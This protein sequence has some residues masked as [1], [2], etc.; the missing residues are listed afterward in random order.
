MIGLPKT[1][2][3]EC[4][5]V[6]IVETGPRNGRTPVCWSVYTIEDVQV[7]PPIC[8]TD[9]QHIKDF[10]DTIVAVYSKKTFACHRGYFDYSITFPPT[11]TYG[12]LPFF[13][14]FNIVLLTMATVSTTMCITIAITK[15]S[16]I[17][18]LATAV[19]WAL[20]RCTTYETCS[21]IVLIIIMVVYLI[22]VN[23]VPE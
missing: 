10:S 21:S 17:T 7:T 13:D 15:I 9:M 12:V 2:R 5:G 18:W 23:T 14:L 1:Y 6:Y 16:T 11:V 22:R 8:T 3:S 4:V 19:F 20:I